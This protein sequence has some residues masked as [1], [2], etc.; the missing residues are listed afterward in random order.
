MIGA[1]VI[2]AATAW[3]GEHD[4]AAPAIVDVAPASVPSGPPR[5]V[6]VAA[7]E[8]LQTAIRA[9]PAG[10]TVR[11]RAGIHHGP[12]VID[13][14]LTVEGEPGASID[15]RGTGSVVIIAA[16]DVTVR[17]LRVTGGGRQAQHDDSGVV[18]GADRF[19]VER[20][21]VDHSY[22]GID[23]RMAS[24]GTVRDCV[25]RGD[26][27]AAFGLRGDGIRLWESSDD[28]IVGNTLVNVRDLVMWYADHNR[29]RGNRVVGSRYGT[30]LMHTVGNVIEDN[31]YEQ[32]VVGVF[33]MYSDDVALRRNQVVGAH[34]EA[35]VGLGFKESSG[36]VVE[37][38]VLV[39]DTTGIYLDTTPQSGS[40]RFTGNLIAANDV[41]VRMH[42]RSVG[43]AFV[44]NAFVADRV[45]AS[46]DARGTVTGVQFDGNHWSDYAGYDL[47]GD[48]FGD[49]P[50]E[51]RS[52]SGAL[53]GRE[54]ALAWF[55]GTAALGL[56]DLFGAAFPM[57]APDVVLTDPRPAIAWAPRA[58]R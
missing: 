29:I 39:D 15:G 7:D 35:G 25:V 12:V 18:V 22:L 33:A 53:L 57:L 32:D 4:A 20:V 26:P 36:V 51:V 30:H 5:T 55:S 13:R 40:G 48:G 50:F 46:V 19:V 58:P 52:A 41:G 37:D 27:D 10:S 43:A 49:L 38:N 9:L 8:D 31:R 11:L 23:L 17:D 45:A 3:A 54:P 21:T 28:D 34:G 56:I 42:G 24:H 47:D 1:A 14:A 2:A 6:R 44:G 16:A